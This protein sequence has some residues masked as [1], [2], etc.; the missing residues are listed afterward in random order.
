LSSILGIHRVASRRYRVAGLI[1][2]TLPPGDQTQPYLGRAV[3]V[4]FGISG[5][6]GTRGMTERKP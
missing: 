2:G 3:A 6:G 1:L 4:Q 5:G